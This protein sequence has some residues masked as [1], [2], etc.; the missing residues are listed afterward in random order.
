MA[1]SGLRLASHVMGG[2]CAVALLSAL[3]PEALAQT[4]ADLVL[5]RLADGASPIRIE[6]AASDAEHG[7]VLGVV[8]PVRT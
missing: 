4:D 5:I 1:V 3:A 8:M 2:A 6:P 7:L